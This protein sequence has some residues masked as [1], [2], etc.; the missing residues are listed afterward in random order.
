MIRRVMIC[1]LFSI[2]LS[3]S[4]I[5]AAIFIN[6]IEL[7][8]AGSDVGTQWI[9]VYNSGTTSVSLTGW[10]LNDTNTG[11]KFTFP[12]TSL[13]SQSFYVLHG[14]SNVSIVNERWQL[15]NG[16]NVLQDDSGFFNESL[17]NGQTLSR[18][19]DGANFVLQQ[20]SLNASNVFPNVAN[21]NTVPTCLIRD[22]RNFSLTANVSSFCISSI[23]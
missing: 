12:S 6:E 5:S 22:G 10:Y 11:N 16:A 20:S 19:P 8:P 13:A 7:D 2:L 1:F 17:D 23:E 9:E 3:V 14:L 15:F 18:V 4:L 21:F